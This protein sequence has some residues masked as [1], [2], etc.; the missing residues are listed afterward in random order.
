M[1]HPDDHLLSSLYMGHPD[2]H[3]L[4]SLY[5]GHPDDHLLS[6]LYMGHLMIFYYH[7][8]NILLLFL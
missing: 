7:F 3:L 6:P 1:G 4:P 8:S 5:M 2:D